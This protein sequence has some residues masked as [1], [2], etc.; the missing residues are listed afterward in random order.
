[1]ITKK[2]LLSY[3]NFNKE[4]HVFMDASD[5]QLGV[6]IMQNNKL[7]AFYMQKMNQAQQKCI[8]REQ[9][10]LSIVETLKSFE[11]ILL[12]QCIVVH[13]DYLNLLNKKLASN[14]LIWWHMLLEEYGPTCVYVKGEK[15]VVANS[16]S[17]LD[18]EPC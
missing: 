15:N 7:L 3:S 5:Y 16:L 1:M 12:G 4:F 9:E 11:N 6:V 10:L 14:H 18:M 13:T 8:T 17:R 2:A